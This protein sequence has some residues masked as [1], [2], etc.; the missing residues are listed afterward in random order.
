MT[1]RKT[2]PSSYL[3]QAARLHER[4]ISFDGHLDIPLEFGQPGSEADKDGPGKFDIPKIRRGKLSGAAA[5]VHAAV[6]RP[7]P[8]G[9]AAGRAQH[10]MRFAGLMQMARD[11]PQDVGI[12]ASPQQFRDLVAQKRFAIVLAFQNAA[13]LDGGLDDLDAWA[14]RGISIFAFTFIGNNG[15][16]DSARPYPFVNGGLHWNG[17]SPLGKQAVH[18]LNDLGV[19]IDVSQLSSAA[20]NDVIAQSHVPVF[21]S[22]SGVRAQVDVDRNFSDTE[23]KALQRNGGLIQI[24]G[25]APYLKSLDN[26]M[27]ADLQATWRRFGLNAPDNPSDMLSV[28]D[29]ATVGWPEDRFWDFLHEFHVVLDLDRPIAST[30]HLVDAIDHAVDLIGIDHVGI[31]SDFNHAGGLSDWMDVGESLNVTAGL[32]SRG[33]EQEAIAKL[34]GEN[35]LRTWQVALDARSHSR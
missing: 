4:L 13:P 19:L 24:V 8:E 11:F 12:A 35:F 30:S 10:E 21:A 31:S 2:A 18:R 9:H 29:P 20:F 25:F 7:T 14:A 22:H 32:L 5:T 33:Y 23:L 27:I 34:W 28:N 26:R 3:E 16:A 6:L 1:N 15:W 17:L